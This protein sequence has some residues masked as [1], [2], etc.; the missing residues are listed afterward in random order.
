MRKPE[1]KPVEPSSGDYTKYIDPA[2]DKDK[3]LRI[4][5][6]A[7]RQYRLERQVE[8]LETDLKQAQQDLRAIAEVELPNA[9]ADAGVEEFRTDKVKVELQTNYYPN[10]PKDT[11]ELF[12]D[13]LIEKG[14]APL[15]KRSIDVE[16]G[17]G[18]KHWKNLIQYLERARKTF[19]F[20]FKVAR[21]VHSSTLRKFVRTEI[22]AQ[23]ELPNTITVHQVR[24]A[25]LSFPAGGNSEI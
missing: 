18:Q 5:E 23:R 1:K 21:S 4:T 3:L 8:K 7:R 12:Y 20:E 6:I 22:E 15:V 19:K 9:M 14:H 13:W 10:V 24:R 11:A 25:V 2:P 16:F 17:M